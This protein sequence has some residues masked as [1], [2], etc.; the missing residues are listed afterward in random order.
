[1]VRREKQRVTMDPWLLVFSTLTNKEGGVEEVELGRLPCS[2]KRSRE[3]E[4]LRKA[5]RGQWHIEEAVAPM[6]VLVVRK[7]LR[8][9]LGGASRRSWPGKHPAA[10]S[11]V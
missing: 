6:A 7:A 8:T 11:Q 10:I 2:K 4:C 9:T 1:V 5:T 3:M